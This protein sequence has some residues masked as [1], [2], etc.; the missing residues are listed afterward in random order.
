MLHVPIVSIH[1]VQY[2]IGHI[3]FL[4]VFYFLLLGLTL[5]PSHWLEVHA[6]LQVFPKLHYIC[7]NVLEKEVHSILAGANLLAFLE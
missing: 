1:T 7:I 2:W 6:E 5:V 4:N 3:T